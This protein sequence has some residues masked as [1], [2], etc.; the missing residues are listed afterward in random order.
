MPGTDQSGPA[1]D[2]PC[3]ACGGDIARVVMLLCD[4]EDDGGRV[5]KTA[6][7]CRTRA[8]VAWRWSDRPETPLE[9]DEALLFLAR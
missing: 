1:W 6:V 7:V 8:H 3:P 2:E 9:V 4:R 5:C